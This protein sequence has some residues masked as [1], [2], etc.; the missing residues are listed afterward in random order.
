MRIRSRSST[1]LA[2][3]LLLAVAGGGLAA[4]SKSSAADV[5]PI[6]S[7]DTAAF[8]TTSTTLPPTTTTL[9]PRTTVPPTTLPPPPTTRPAP[10]VTAP[11]PPTTTTT[12][13]PNI[14]QVGESGPAVMA[15]QQALS[16]LGYWLGT[17]NGQFGSLTQQ[18]VWALQ[19][20]AGIPPTGKVD[21]A[22]A[23]ALASGDKPTP[24]TT[25]GYVIEVD[26]TS[27]VLMVVN[28]GQVQWILNTSTGGH[29]VY[30][31]HGV[32][33]VAITPTGQFATYRDVDGT[34]VAPLGTLW[35]PRFFV[36]GYAIHGD[37]YVPATP[38]S[39]GCVRVTNSAID[40]IWANN[41]DPDGTEVLVYT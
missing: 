33:S 31:E 37:S 23:A 28:N 10:V 26:L 11:P 39:H 19:K 29:Y 35:R 38:V 7:G 36:G 9:P 2:S 41:I 34:D 32:R 40:W 27:D 12:L 5:A 17:P 14:P 15:V 1:L 22:T 8:P 3:A 20:V 18:A 30:Y 25:S 16:N 13:D 21:A 24:K 6:S 4:C